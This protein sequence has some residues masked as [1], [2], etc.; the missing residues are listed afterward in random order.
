MRRRGLLTLG[1]AALVPAL[2][3]CRQAEPTKRIDEPV[4]Q[5]IVLG[6]S[7][8]QQNVAWRS[9]QKRSIEKAAASTNVRITFADA[10]ARQVDQIRAIQSLVDQRVDVIA[11]T[12]IVDSGWDGVLRQAKQA[13]IPVL[14]VDGVLDSTDTSL[15][16]GP[17]GADF[18]AEGILAAINLANLTR[19]GPLANV[20]EIRGTNG[21]AQTSERSQGF[22]ETLKSNPRFRIVDAKS[23]GWT[24]S[25]GAAA[26]T[27]LLA[28]HTDIDAVYAH[29]DY[30]ALGVVAA[31]DAAG[32]Q[33]GV[34]VKIC[35][36]DAT[37]A[38]LKVLAAGKMNYIV[39][40]DPHIGKELIEAVV[41]LHLG[42]SLPRRNPPDRIV[43]DKFSAKAALQDRD[44]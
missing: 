11:F 38:G 20:V 44:Y 31:L 18:R 9:A 14:L 17:V 8:L 43:F 22:V 21:W 19:S 25:G 42:G 40:S 2:A 5:T 13:K 28:R 33:P 30:M 23:G 7:P 6:Y 39:E 3:A 4:D 37:E 41:D 16:H 36:V 27:E 1:A 32:R 26:M 10:V 12:P 29:N 34:K 24:E 35:T 15:F